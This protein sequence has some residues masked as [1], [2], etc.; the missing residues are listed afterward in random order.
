MPICAASNGTTADIRARLSAPELGRPKPFPDV[1][2]HVAQALGAEPQRCAVVED[3][4]PGVRAGVAAGMT[5]F[6]YTAH[7]DAAALQQAGAVTFTDM[8]DLVDLLNESR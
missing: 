3:R 6:G 7:S 4:L 8:H 1:F 5:V 2:V